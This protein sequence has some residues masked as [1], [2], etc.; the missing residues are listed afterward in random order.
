MRFYMEDR[1]MVE[2]VDILIVDEDMNFATALATSL[3]ARGSNVT[4]AATAAESLEKLRERPLT[5]IILMDINLPDRSGMDL[6][7][8]IKRINQNLPIIMV[9]G[10]AELD[11]AVAAIKKGAC[12]YVVKP[13]DIEPLWLR[14]E[15]A[16]ESHRVLRSLKHFEREMSELYGFKQFIYASREMHAVID[17][18]KQLTNSDA[19]VLITG[20]SGVGKELAARALH[21]NSPRRL[22]PFIA[23]SCAAVPETLIENELFGHEKGAFTGAYERRIGKFEQ[24]NGGT[25]FLDEIGDLSPVIQTKLLR[26]LQERSFHRIG[27]VQEIKV[28]VRVICASNRDL[29][30]AVENDEFRADL[31]YRISVLPVTLPSLRDRQDDIVLLA[32]HFLTAF[33]RKIGKPFEGFSDDALG[34]MRS[35]S[36]PGN[37][38]ELQNAVERAVVF[39]KPP[40]LQA[41]DITLG[42]LGKVI[43]KDKASGEGVMSLKEME[44]DHIAN[45]LTHFDWNISKAAQRLGIGRDTLYRKIKQYGLKRKK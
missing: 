16:I 41:K 25:I 3:S 37:V 20:E 14:I 26:V 30:A 11:T 36:W 32:E 34:L 10:D 24:A 4:V 6:I 42:P 19:T 23:A 8:E 33:S 39:G 40:F 38:R 5:D 35:Y 9:T 22:G 15:N 21:F 7:N 44:A 45:A 43:R 13:I 12:D 2:N 29:T 31:F 27:G 18:M 28:D 1:P 17:Q